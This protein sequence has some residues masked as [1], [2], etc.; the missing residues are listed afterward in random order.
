MTSGQQLRMEGIDANLAAAQS[1]N[2]TYRDHAETILAGFARSGREFTADDIRQAI[3]AG[4]EPHHPN[5]LPSLLG[6]WSAQERIQP[7]DWA[8]SQRRSRHSSR[9]RVWVGNPYKQRSD[10]A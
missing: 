10:A 5:V 4:L 9:N 2:R 6:Q 7:V 8:M 3:P 1:I